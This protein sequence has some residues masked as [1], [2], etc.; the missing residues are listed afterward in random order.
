MRSDDHLSDDLLIQA[1]DDELPEPEAAVTALH[2]SGCEECRQRYHGLALLSQEL[3]SV[4]ASTAVNAS[5]EERESLSHALESRELKIA[6]ARSPGKVLQR[7]GWG[8]AIAATLAIGVMLAPHFKNAAGSAN[9]AVTA[10]QNSGTF[11]VDG[12]AFVPVPYSNSSL[13][14]DAPH[15]VQMRVP[16]SSL[17]AAGVDFG[18]ISS[19]LARND[20]SVAADVL[21]GMDG[22]PLGVHVTG[23]E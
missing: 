9:L 20:D 17:L 23:T 19:D 7:F 8:M 6:D 11:N 16:V 14:L 13:P 22:Q 1:I 21:L 4:V 12:E 5:R 10:S 3:E 2:L 15:I 18:P